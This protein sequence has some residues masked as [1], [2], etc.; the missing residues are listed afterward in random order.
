MFNLTKR[1]LVCFGAGALIGV[2]LFFLLRKPLGLSPAAIVMVISMLPAFLL[3]MYEK[4]GQPLEKVFGNIIQV[5]FTRP[6]KRPYVANNFY[7]AVERQYQLD[8]EVAL[9]VRKSKAHPAGAETDRSRSR[10]GKKD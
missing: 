9:I 5:C 8:K 6:R 2:P 1:Q 4:N 7:A 3:A 10:K